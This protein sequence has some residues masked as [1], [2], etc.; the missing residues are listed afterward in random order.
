M[1]FLGGGGCAFKPKKDIP[2]LEGK[3][4]LVTGGN[5]GLGKQA[6]LDFS[7]H[8]P[9][10]I[11]LAARNAD[12]ANEAIEEIRAKVPDAPVKFL[13]LDLSSFESIKKAAE[14]F[15]AESDRLDILMLNAGIMGTAPA[16]TKD[17]YELQFGTNHMGH[18]LLTKL[19]MPVMTKTAKDDTAADVRIVCLSSIAHKQAPKQ[20]IVFDSLKTEA[21]NMGPFERYGQSKIANI[22]YA[23]QL[24]KQHPEFTVS[25]IHPGVV[26]TNLASGMSGMPAV[27][28]MMSPLANFFFTPVDEGAKNQLWASVSKG[29]KSGEY[30]EPVGVAGKC[31]AVGKNEELAKKLWDWT[32]KE[33]KGYEA[34]L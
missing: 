24:A 23:K 11:W 31:N 4:I 22:L 29:V 2:S 7:Q 13:Q 18:A 3:V 33:L 34:K 6:I 21:E 20:G 14:T 32:E 1:P 26:R 5:I 19:L 25:A 27:I 16:L 12:K 28:R 15:T 17:G 30:Y 8:H 10:Q 9:R